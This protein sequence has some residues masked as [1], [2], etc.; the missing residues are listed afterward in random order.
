MRQ[1]GKIKARVPLQLTQKEWRAVR[2][3]IRQQCLEQTEQYEAQLDV[4]TL[5][6]IN[7]VFGHGKSKLEYFYSEMF[8]LREEMKEYYGNGEDE[9]MGDFAMYIKL[10]EK[11]I[12]VQ[13]MYEEQAVS[14]RFKVKVK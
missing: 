12:D 11:G 1:I 9:G 2:S 6:A 8:K 13:K 10:K 5:Y 4:V 14:R 3:E 7:R